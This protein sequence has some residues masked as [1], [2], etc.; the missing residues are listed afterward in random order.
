MRWFDAVYTLRWCRTAAGGCEEQGGEER[1]QRRVCGLRPSAEPTRGISQASQCPRYRTSPQRTTS[2][3][4]QPQRTGPR[5]RGEP[6]TLSTASHYGKQLQP[7]NAMD[8][9]CCRICISYPLRREFQL[10][11]GGLA[12]STQKLVSLPFSAP[13]TLNT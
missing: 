9:T 5:E 3:P 10:S 7:C 1:S 4:T 8:I 6:W 2:N 13:R 11:S 12:G